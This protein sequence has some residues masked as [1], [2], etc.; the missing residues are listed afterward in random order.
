SLGLYESKVV[1]CF[2]IH[3]SMSIW[4]TLDDSPHDC[5]LDRPYFCMKWESQ[6]SD[7]LNDAVFRP[8]AIWRASCF[9][10]F[11]SIGKFGFARRASW[12]FRNNCFSIASYLGTMTR[13]RV[14]NPFLA[15]SA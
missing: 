7:A 8:P 9:S 15:A 10:Q 3:S 5:L 1:L 4:L 6:Q 2:A 12:K 13:L 11:P 14:P